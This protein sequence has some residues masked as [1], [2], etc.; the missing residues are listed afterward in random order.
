MDVSALSDLL[1]WSDLGLAGL[2]SVGVWM[3]MTGRL[4]PRGTVDE[5]LRPR[6]ERLRDMQAAYE[7]SE[8]ANAVKDKQIGE[9]LENSRISVQVLQALRD[10]TSTDGEPR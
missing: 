5:L 7:R 2:V 8:E 1:P 6:D 9:L 10:A 4:V 3:I